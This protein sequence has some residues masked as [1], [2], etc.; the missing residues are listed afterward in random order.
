M[1]GIMDCAVLD[2]FGAKK[3]RVEVDIARGLPNFTLVGLA[4]NSVKESR[5]RVQAA[6]S[7][8]GFDFPKA[9]IS[10]NLAPADVQ[11][12]GTAFD[13]SIALAILLASG[14]IPEPKMAGIAAIGEL[15]LTGEIRPVR[16]MLALAE[17]IRAQGFTYLLVAK[18]NAQEAALITGL[19]IKI[20]SSFGEMVETILSGKL[21]HLPSGE[22]ADTVSVEELGIDMSDVVGQ[23]EARRA[24]LIAAAGNHNLLFIGGPG[25]GKSMMACRLPTILPP[26][27]YPEALTLT[28]IHSIAG[29]TLA[30]N[31]VKA[32]PFRAP[33]H[34]ITRAGLVGGGSSFIRPGE[35]SLASF[36][37]LF[38][39]ELLEFPRTVLEVLRQPL[40]NGEITLSRANHSITYPAEISLA[41]ALNPC[42][43]G[44]FG[45]SKTDCTCSPLA[46][47][48][49]QSRLSGP[50]IDRIDLHVNVPP[51]DL[52]LMATC[53]PGENSLS[54]RKKVINARKCQTLR[55][56]EARTNGKMTRSEIKKYSLIND[57]ALNFLV[58]SANRLRVSARG[59]DRILRV[60]RTIADLSEEKNIHEHHIAEALHYRPSAGFVKKLN[61]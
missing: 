16:G 43:C 14:V 37:V 52:K 18:E 17:S 25:S 50:L 31:L 51:I 19:T 13:L 20:V 30:G 45:Q 39:D 26:L 23:E 41:A 4:E 48:K 9:R 5:V 34:S 57:R 40:E 6:I 21:D 8:A 53:S 3:I 55:L 35:I 28:K 46:I 11:K 61:E 22:Q 10:V 60:S 42:P 15:S 1:L 27:S 32:R 49:Y 59:F 29:L 54:M 33:H 44:H 56:G 47:S 36:G 24:V 12:S 38:L 2:G 7:N 58:N